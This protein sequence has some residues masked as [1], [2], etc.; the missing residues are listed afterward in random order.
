MSLTTR[1]GVFPV[2]SAGSWVLLCHVAF[3]PL[4]PPW[5]GIHPRRPFPYR[6]ELLQE[7][8]LHTSPV[9][10]SLGS[11]SLVTYHTNSMLS[12]TSYVAL[13]PEDQ[14][15]PEGRACLIPL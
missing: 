10:A 8:S 1:W 12:L 2:L 13:S 3:L 9:W 7:A 4:H 14:E 5:L 6:L 15:F 11:P